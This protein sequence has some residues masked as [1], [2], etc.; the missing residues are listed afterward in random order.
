MQI[1]KLNMESVRT[2]RMNFKKN[3][4]DK[5]VRNDD[6][7]MGIDLSK[8][9]TGV[10]IIDKKENLIFA[11][12]IV[13]KGSN[14]L[15]VILDFMIAFD[16]IL[17]KYNPGI[18]MMED[19]FLRNNNG[20]LNAFTTLAKQHGVVISMLYPLGLVPYTLHQ[21]SIKSFCGCK[22][23]EEVFKYIVDKYNIKNFDFE[24]HNDITDAIAV[25]LNWR[26]Q[27]KKCRIK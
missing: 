10:A 5:I 4:I 21:A 16:A 3:K 18:V 13:P 19:I 14:D 22:K 24:T 27:K 12:K 17:K 8:M 9:S 11:D 7:I 20:R 1:R 6:L 15:Y 23:K 2:A 26:N 25:A